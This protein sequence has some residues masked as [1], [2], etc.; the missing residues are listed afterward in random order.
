MNAQ[1]A[2]AQR[3]YDN[4]VP[5]SYYDD[6]LERAH[7]KAINDFW[8]VGYISIPTRCQS[9]GYAREAIS[10]D[11]YEVFEAVSNGRNDYFFPLRRAIREKSD[12]RTV[13]AARRFMAGM[14][15]YVEEWVKE[16]VSEDYG[17]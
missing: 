11:L 1:L 14:N 15:E 8:D 2:V 7:Q 13:E 5:D 4:A 6:P 3:N 9:R 17:S 12:A 16:N 10:L